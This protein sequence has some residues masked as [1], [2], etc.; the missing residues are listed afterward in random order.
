MTSV[1]SAPEFDCSKQ[2]FMHEELNATP[3]IVLLDF[4]KM[5]R[6]A[7]NNISGVQKLLSSLFQFLTQ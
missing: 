2:C 3:I 5:Q 1:D 6:S 4:G 7:G